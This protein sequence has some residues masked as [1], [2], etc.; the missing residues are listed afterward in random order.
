MKE[1][2]GIQIIRLTLKIDLDHIRKCKIYDKKY[3]KEIPYKIKS[4]IK[5]N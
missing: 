2:S 4:N 1:L 5:K 3:S